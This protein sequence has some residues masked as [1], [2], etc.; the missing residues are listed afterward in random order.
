[1]RAHVVGAG[2]SIGGHRPGHA[3]RGP[4]PCFLFIGTR[5]SV[6]AYVIGQCNQQIPAKNRVP[7]TVA[8]GNCLECEA[9][10]LGHSTGRCHSA[11]VG[12][13][14]RRPWAMTSPSTRRYTGRVTATE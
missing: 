1:M 10:V 12:R 8:V 7:V 13:S 9:A 2:V 11:I 5:S 14:R 4:E 3:L 6:R